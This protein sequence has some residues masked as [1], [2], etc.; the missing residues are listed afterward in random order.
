MPEGQ[1]PHDRRLG[2]LKDLNGYFPFTPSESKEAWAERAARVK[3]QILVATGLWPMPERTPPN[4]VVH[5]KVDRDTYTVER[6]YLESY[7]GHF[8]TGSL[9]RPKGKSGK[10]PGVL[11]PHGH[12]SQGRFYDAGVDE[13]RKQ[14]VAGAERFENGGHS[15]MQARCMQL[16]R[17]G[18]VVFHYDMVGYADSVQIP[19]SLAHGFSKQRP[20]I[21]HAG[22]LGLLQHP[23][24]SADAKHHGT[25]NLQ[26]DP[27][28]DWFSELPDV[29]PARIA[30]TG[31]SGGGTQTFI[32][33]AIDERP[34]VVFPAVMVSTAMQGGCTCENC[35]L[36]RVGTGNI[37][38][39][40]MAAPRP[41]GMTGADDWTKE[42]ATKGY[43]ELKQ[44]Y[45]MLGVPELVMAKVLPQFGHNYNFVSREVMYQFMNQY[46]GLGLPEPVIEDDFSLLST[47]EMTV[48][49]EAHPKP[50]A[51]DDYERSL[52]KYMTD[53]SDRQIAALTPSDSTTLARFREIVGGG[54]DVIIG[55]GLTVGRGLEYEPMEE[56]PQGD[57]VEFDSMLRNEPYGEELPIVILHPTN[58]NKR[59]VIWIHEAGKSGLFDAEGK[60]TA[61]VDRIAQGRLCRSR[62]GLAVPG[63]ISGRR[64][65][66]GPRAAR[67][68]SARVRRLH[69]RLQC[70]A[71]CPAR[72]RHPDAR[73]VLQ[74][75]RR[76]TAAGR[77]RRLGHCRCV[78]GGGPA[79]AGGAVTR[80]AIDTGGFRFASIE[81]LTD[82][83]FLPGAVKYGDVPGLL[84]LGAPG[85]TWLAGEEPMP[86]G[87]V[88]AAYTAAGAGGKLQTFAGPAEQRAIEAV[89]WL[90]RP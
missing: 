86:P 19:Q 15:P 12:W 35:C 11:C 53:E 30:V 41:L 59:V 85:E 65:A 33:A 64:Q 78:G 40:A 49:D 26:F 77:S 56:N 8:V 55:R 32:L 36:L 16:A 25:A 50:P 90:V 42:L 57:Y 73:L 39:A 68:Q 82:L 67:R 29:D 14:I 47:A 22:K 17:M 72:T 43:P 44:H 27:A 2:P 75:L 81:S 66:A 4:A 51:G 1:V 5:G 63:R 10:L 76:R 89:K 69:A 87:L 37:E 48:W 84:A 46:L 24:R 61:E 20:G 34:A 28:L 13:A 70:G 54:F 52:V 21:Q 83:N 88:S 60:P 58:W 62:S 79:Q 6:V 38:F 9:Y 80:A 71:A 7:P 74:H 31:A 18:S 3:R 23:G 45:Q